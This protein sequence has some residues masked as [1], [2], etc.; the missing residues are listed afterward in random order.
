M[1]NYAPSNANHRCIPCFD[2]LR[3]VLLALPFLVLNIINVE[4]LHFATTSQITSSKGTN[5]VYTTQAEI[6]VSNIPGEA[7]DNVAVNERG[8]DLVEGG[9]P[10][11]QTSHFAHIGTCN[12]TSQHEYQTIEIDILTFD[13]FVG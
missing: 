7:C 2:K 6:D 3:C 9:T 10:G 5:A 11:D 1:I 8:E 13:I 12:A 4:Q